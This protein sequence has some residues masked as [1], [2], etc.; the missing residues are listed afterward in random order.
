MGAI[1]AILVI[2]TAVTMVMALLP[3]MV[4][5]ESATESLRQEAERW[6]G[7]IMG[8]I[9]EDGVVIDSARVHRLKEMVLQ[10]GQGQGLRAKVKVLGHMTSE[11]VLLSMGILPERLEE[12]YVLQEPVGFMD[13]GSEVKA[14]LL[15][16]EVW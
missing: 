8:E 7:R 13:E 11:I 15:L 6:R 1:L 14:A 4:T 5:H 10:T 16:V 9:S 3:G 2:S 12:C